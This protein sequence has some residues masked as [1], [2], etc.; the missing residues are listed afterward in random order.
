MSDF[1]Y[2]FGRIS[3][4]TLASTIAEL[5]GADDNIVDEAIAVLVRSFGKADAELAL[6]DAGVG[7][8]VKDSRFRDHF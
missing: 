3:K 7:Y 6:E 1:S 4:N 8:L 5:D 2:L